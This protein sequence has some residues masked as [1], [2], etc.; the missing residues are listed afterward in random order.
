MRFLFAIA[1]L[2]SPLSVHAESLPP[3]SVWKSAT[4]GCCS[5]WIAHLQANGFTVTTHD[6]ADLYNVKK[7]AGIPAELQSCHTARI[8]TYLIEGHVPAGDIKRLLQ[9]KAAIAGLATPGMPQGSPGME[10]GR[11]GWRTA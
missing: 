10:T 2:L 8:G 4:C 7:T 9:E 3:I 5:K 1:L 11:S 6:V